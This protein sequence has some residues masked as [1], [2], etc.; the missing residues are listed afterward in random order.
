MSTNTKTR[1]TRT[2]S[3]KPEAHMWV[4]VQKNDKGEVGQSD[5][6]AIA[7]V[8]ASEVKASGSVMQS[9]CL[10]IISGRI[11]PEI[12]EAIKKTGG[13]ARLFNGTISDPDVAALKRVTSVTPEALRTA[14]ATY[15]GNAKRVRCIS[16]QALRKSLNEPAAEKSAS[17]KELVIA[18]AVA[19][20]DA[21]DT[22]P[23]ELFDIIIAAMPKAEA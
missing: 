12:R 1:T 9:L 20:P 7:P 11:D 17:F 21:L 19:N 16:L 2:T 13:I 15:V 3:V 6:L 14:W 23:V 18:W 4:P 22:L 8:K 5:A 10:N